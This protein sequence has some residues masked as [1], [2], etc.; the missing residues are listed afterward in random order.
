MELRGT[1]R[2]AAAVV[3]AALLGPGALRL[4]G[5]DTHPG[6]PTFAKDIAPIV[7]AHCAPCHHPGGSAPFPLLTYSDV[8][9]RATLVGD[10]TKRRSM[11]PWKAEPGFGGPFLNQHP[12]AED[13]IE[14]IQRW[15][16]SGAAEGNPGDLPRTP[17]ITDGW[18]L[19]RPDQIVT[20][21][22]PYV[23][24][25][26][27]ADVLRIFA[28]PVPLTRVRYVRGL[29]FH[30]GNSS[31]VHHANIRI[32]R[33]SRSREL[34]AQDPAPGYD[35]LMSNSAVYPDGHFLGW[36]PGQLAP[37]LPKGLAWRLDPGTD[38]VVEL[39]MLPSGKPEMVQP[40]FGFFFTDDP[41]Q[42][43][44]VMLRIGSESIDI[45]P[46]V[47][48]HRVV[49][50]FE[51]PVDV[52]VQAVQPHAHYRARHVKGFA[53][54]PSGETKWLIYIK[55]WDFRWQH[56][57]RLEKPLA[58]PKGSRI[59]MDYTYDNSSDNLRNPMVPPQRVTWGQR[60]IDEMGNLWIQVLTRDESDGELLSRSFRPKAAADDASGYEMMI[61]RDPADP[62]YHNDA[63]VLYLELGRTRE[64][65]A[66]FAAAL[67]L[68]PHV[69]AAHF[70]VGTALA[71]ARRWD[72][73]AAEYRAA[74]EITPDYA[75]A[76]INLGNALLA[77]A[78][79]AEAV[80]HYRAALRVEPN[81]AL[82]HNNLGQALLQGGS[83]E[84]ALAHFRD[85]I[86]LDPTYA[87]PHYNL[88]RA[89]TRVDRRGAI[90]ELQR[91]IR[92]RPDWSEAATALAELRRERR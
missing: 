36:T 22:Q 31:A 41:P 6:S 78:A 5:A 9:P 75:L 43:T 89:L 67:E 45:A 13:Q 24:P 48:D 33:T 84:E 69:A 21:P 49:D 23:L 11:P 70:N 56:V 7:F 88:A 83:R 30:A 62:A 37:L 54:L 53:V 60:S 19:G 14:T 2:V 44:P 39:H 91:A 10:V 73:A 32:D 57:Y 46:G 65:I 51:L 63:A 74:L 40:S 64:A 86:R 79:I 3:V 4:F 1:L 15:V 80:V 85:A 12:L 50:S 28:I 29:E 82:A 71:A 26:G 87:E 8:R 42:R 27:G 52:E 61:R 25:A 76:H 68:Q 90:S 81:N 58:L 16:A 59:S 55:D 35:G 92:L 34:D 77:R 47:K 20:L 17:K 38:L 66:H 18:Q 72:E